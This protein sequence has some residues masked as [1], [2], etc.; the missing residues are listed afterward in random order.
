MTAPVRLTIAFEDALSEALLDA[1]LRQ[2][3]PHLTVVQR[4]TRGI[5]RRRHD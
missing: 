3:A 5:G 4:L 1:I 2:K